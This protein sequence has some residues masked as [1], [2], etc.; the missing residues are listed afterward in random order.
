MCGCP[1]DRSKLISMAIALRKELVYS[2]YADL[3]HAFTAEGRTGIKL[4]CQEER[5]D[6]EYVLF[7]ETHNGEEEMRGRFDERVGQHHPCHLD[8][9]AFD[10]PLPQWAEDEECSSEGTHETQAI[11]QV[12]KL[13]QKMRLRRH[14]PASVAHLT[15]HSGLLVRTSR[16]FAGCLAFV[17]AA[18]PVAMRSHSL[19]GPN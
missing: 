6:Q 9:Y 15:M 5:C 11:D 4:T 10:E 2:R 12:R 13:R 3:T 8:L 14:L 17:V 18:V 19:L 1:P 7:C 16:V